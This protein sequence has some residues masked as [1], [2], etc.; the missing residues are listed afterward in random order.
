M[1]L[2]GWGNFYV[3]VGSTGWVASEEVYVPQPVPSQPTSDLWKQRYSLLFLTAVFV[4][5]FAALTRRQTNGRSSPWWWRMVP[6]IVSSSALKATLAAAPL[7]S[8]PSST[9]AN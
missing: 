3:I 2:G 9:P 5:F 7:I 1:E 8:S 6:V 4:A